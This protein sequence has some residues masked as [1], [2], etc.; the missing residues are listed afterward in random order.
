MKE[1]VS[2]LISEE[3]VTRRVTEIAQTLDDAFAGKELTLVC[4]LKGGVIFLVDLAKRLKKTSVEFDFMDISSYNGGT[5]SS[6]TIKI[7]KDLEN[8]IEGKN[9]VLVE[10]IIDSGRTLSHVVKHLQ[11]QH[12]KSLTVC[13]LLDK[14]DRREVFDVTPDYIGFAIP[15]QFAVGYGMDYEQKYRNLP[16]IGVLHIS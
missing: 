15:D 5:A 12:P 14:P 6:G 3:D 1:T 10:D 2:V 8:S 7:N 11:G 13:T 16:F 9:V 4:L